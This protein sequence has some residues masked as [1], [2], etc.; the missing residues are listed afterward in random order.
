MYMDIYA[1][2]YMYMYTCPYTHVCA[3]KLQGSDTI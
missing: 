1:C 2:V 3:H